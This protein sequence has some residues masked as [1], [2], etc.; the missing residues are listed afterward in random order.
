MTAP[1]MHVIGFDV[2][3]SRTGWA[4]LTYEHGELVGAHTIPTDATMP[5]PARL[6]VIDQAVRA[7]I[8]TFDRRGGVDVAIESGFMARSGSVTRKL[9]MA[10]GV[11]VLAM[12]Q[13]TGGIQPHEVAPNEVKKLAT[14][15]G[16]AKKDAVMEAAVARWGEQANDP[17]IADAAWVAEHCR[18]FMH[19]KFPDPEETP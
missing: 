9:A 17:D 2:S 11:A 7:A 16:D 14:G 3:L 1:T 10:W 12:W 15:R 19:A 18:L 13:R 4:A 6:D 5:L 8:S